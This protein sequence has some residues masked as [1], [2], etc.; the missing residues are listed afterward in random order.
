MS[1]PELDP[2]EYLFTEYALKS[3]VLLEGLYI[4]TPLL[5][6]GPSTYSEKNKSVQSCAAIDETKHRFKKVSEFFSY[7]YFFK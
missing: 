7:L 6:A 2:L 1:G 5:F 3:N 4:S